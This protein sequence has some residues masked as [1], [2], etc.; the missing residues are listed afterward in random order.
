MQ[1]LLLSRFHLGLNAAA[2]RV[3]SMAVLLLPWKDRENYEFTYCLTTDID[4]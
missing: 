3:T 2:S 1:D 4:G